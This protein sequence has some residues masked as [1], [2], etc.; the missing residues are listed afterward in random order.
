MIKASLGLL[1]LRT[2]WAIGALVGRPVTAILRRSRALRPR[3][4]IEVAVFLGTAFFA[5]LIAIALAIVH[6]PAR[7]ITLRS[8]PILGALFLARFKR[9]VLAGRA[10]SLVSIETAILGLA[11]SAALIVPPRPLAII[12]IESALIRALLTVAISPRRRPRSAITVKAAIVARRRSLAVVALGWALAVVTI[13]SLTVA[14]WR[15]L[16][17]VAI[18]PLS[19]TRRRS[20]AI[21]ALRRPLAIVAIE[22][23]TV[24]LRRPLAIEP[25]FFA[26]ATIISVHRRSTWLC[27]LV[28]IRVK[29]ALRIEATLP[30]LFLLRWLPIATRWLSRARLVALKHARFSRAGRSS[31]KLATL[32][33]ARSAITIL[34]PLLFDDDFRVAALRGILFGEFHMY[35]LEEGLLFTCGKIAPQSQRN[36]RDHQ[37]SDANPR[38]PVNNNV[39]CI[40]HPADNVIHPFVK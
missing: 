36:P 10:W 11:W 34:I 28:L 21:V 33:C 17:I 30:A 16:P 22:P 24:A 12:S 31:R 3:T 9:P 35:C 14:R 2:S 15:S 38:Q 6:M 19:I 8:A 27:F 7:L 20:L 26:W 18:K 32:R 13:E 40:H 37:W 5:G 23:L 4:V 25:A 29:I 1:V 39:R